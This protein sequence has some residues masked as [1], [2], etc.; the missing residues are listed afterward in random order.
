MLISCRNIVCLDCCLNNRTKLSQELI[1]F[2]YFQNKLRAFNRKHREVSF[3][4]ATK[5]VI[6]APF[7]AIHTE[8]MHE[9]FSSSH[10][11]CLTHT[12]FMNG[13]KLITLYFQFDF[14]SSLT[15]D[16]PL[17]LK[18]TPQFLHNSLPCACICA[19]IGVWLNSFCVCPFGCLLKTCLCTRH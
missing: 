18:D 1:R 16:F 19:C 2:R 14:H 6:T 12:L 8:F 4:V 10:Q 11:Q 5:H 13:V 17:D 7:R 9:S 3:T 15:S